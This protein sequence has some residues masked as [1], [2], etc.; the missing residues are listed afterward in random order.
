MLA[1][2][3]RLAVIP[4]LVIVGTSLPASPAQALNSFTCTSGSRLY[5]GDMVGY[6][7]IASGCAPGGPGITIPEGTFTCVY[8]NYVP[9]FGYVNGR[10]C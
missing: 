1:W 8:V 3:K 6:V 4:L 7:I 2:V 5:M 9:E 10:G